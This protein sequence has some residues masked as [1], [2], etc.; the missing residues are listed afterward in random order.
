[1]RRHLLVAIGI[2]LV[3]GMPRAARAASFVFGTSFS[4]TPFDTIAM[5]PFNPA[6]GTL[7]SVNVSIAGTLAVDGF[8]TPLVDGTGAPIPY[9]YVVGAD[10]D[11]DG[12]IDSYFDFASAAHF[13]FTGV[14]NS[15]G[16]FHESTPFSYTFTFNSTTDLAGSVIPS[17]SGPITPPTSIVG[18]R[19]SFL[20]PI[21]GVNQVLLTQSVLSQQPLLTGLTVSSAGS[22]TVT[23]NY[24]PTPVPEPASLLLLGSGLFGVGM[25]RLR[26]RRAARG[27]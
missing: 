9:A 13:Q 22:I 11:F 3:V 20:P 14:I 1:M 18:T 8:A 25:R 26:L 4:A 16:A 15:G 10:Q 27:A 2:V 19:A 23:Y 6:L 7:Q 24:E 17:V 21:F 12:L 5:T